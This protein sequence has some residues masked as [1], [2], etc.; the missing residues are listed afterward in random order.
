MSYQSYEE[1]QKRL[2]AFWDQ[3]MSDE[4]EGEPFAG[5]DSSDEFVPS[6]GS[7]SDS[8]GSYVPKKKTRTTNEKCLVQT[9]DV[10]ENIAGPSCSNKIAPAKSMQVYLF[11]L[12][13]F[14]FNF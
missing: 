12:C 11:F 3:I 13:F 1:Q 2:Q 10:V 5:D 7:E 8:D 9:T 4:D 14:I 6:D